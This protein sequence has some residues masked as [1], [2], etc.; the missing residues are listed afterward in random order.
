[1]QIKINKIKKQDLEKA[2]EFCLG[3]FKE[4]NWPKEFVYGF[5]NLKEFFGK[6]REVFFLAKLNKRILGCAG[7]KELSDKKGLIK[8]FYVA[9]DFRGKGVSDLMLEKIKR[10]AKKNKYQVLVLDIFNNNLRAKKFFQSHGFFIFKPRANKNWQESQHP[11]LF[12]FR[13]LNLNYGIIK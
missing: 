3:I 10:F 11:E 5:E 2:Q 13:K 1:M 6:N 9:K 4:L 7:L 12:E 8:R